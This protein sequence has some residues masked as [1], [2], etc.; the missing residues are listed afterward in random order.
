MGGRAINPTIMGRIGYSGAMRLVGI[1]CLSLAVVTALVAFLSLSST[2]PFLLLLHLLLSAGLFICG[3]LSLK[4][5]VRAGYA[6]G[7]VTL[8][9]A[10]VY[11]YQFLARE[12]LFPGGAMLLFSFFCLFLITLGV[13]LSLQ[14]E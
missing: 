13:F 11:S 6:G 4:G 14:E 5:Q 9:V 1:T 7:L 8:L 3:G 2:G 10:I 12:S